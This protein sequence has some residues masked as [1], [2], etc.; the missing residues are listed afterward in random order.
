MPKKGL[1]NSDF[2]DRELERLDPP[3]SKIPG[4]LE[5]LQ[6]RIDELE[7]LLGKTSKSIR[8]LRSETEALISE[9]KESRGVIG[10][11]GPGKY[12]G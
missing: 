12:S 3:A 9:I 10:S 8:H 1:K 4:E 5:D 11:F 7:K 6:E 2:L